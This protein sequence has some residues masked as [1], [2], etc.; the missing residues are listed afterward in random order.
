[1]YIIVV[2]NS[3]LG[4]D[5]PTLVTYRVISPFKVLFSQNFAEK[6]LA[7]ILNLQCE[8]YDP[9]VY[10]KVTLCVWNSS[11]VSRWLS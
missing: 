6:K 7:K 11:S 3:Q 1:M 4:C 9:G 10:D 8:K 5:F 2:E